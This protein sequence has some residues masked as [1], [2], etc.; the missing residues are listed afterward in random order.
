M[1]AIPDDD[2]ADAHGDTDP[3]RPLD[4]RAAYLD[5]VAVADIVLDRRREPWRGHVE[6]DRAGAEPQPQRGE[7]TGEDHHQGAD[8]DREALH[9]AFGRKPSPHP[10]ET[11]TEPMQTGVRSRQQPSRPMTCRL[12][13]VL[14]PIGII[15]LRGLD[16]GMQT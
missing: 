11:V 12:V 2:V 5:G 10:C 7:T 13:L 14:I 6:I 16:V 15:P 9:P 4:L 8:H 3:P 1:V